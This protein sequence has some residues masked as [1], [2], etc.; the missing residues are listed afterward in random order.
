MSQERLAMRKIKEI[1]RLKWEASLS[2]RAIARACKISH[3]T[4]SDTI[5]WAGATGLSWP[6]PEGMGGEELNQKLFPETAQ[7]SEAQKTLPDW[8]QVPSDLTLSPLLTPQRTDSR[9]IGALSQSLQI[10]RES[11]HMIRFAL[12]SHTNSSL[13][14]E[15]AQRH[16]TLKPASLLPLL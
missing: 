1:L 14:H 8:K 11:R 2:N 4:V 3:S 10:S 13:R 12:P 7:A 5:R 9:V 15:T 6:L 16:E